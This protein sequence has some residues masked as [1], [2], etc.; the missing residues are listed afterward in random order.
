MLAARVV[1]GALFVEIVFSY[2]GMGT[3]I[4]EALSTRDYPVLQ[5]AL[6]VTAAVV[7]TTN[8]ALDMSYRVLDP[9]I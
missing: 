5:G 2:P 8:L 6:L 4:R 3:L 7:L 9:R 1:P